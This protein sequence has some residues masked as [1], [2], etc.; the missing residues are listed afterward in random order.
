MLTEKFTYFS[1]PAIPD[2][3]LTFV[4]N[5]KEVSIDIEADGLHHYFA[6]VC[7]IQLNIAD[8]IYIVDPLENINTAMLFQA[9]GKK[10]KKSTFERN[11]QLQCIPVRTFFINYI[12]FS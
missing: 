7:L 11:L 12:F 9:I 2:K 6:R 3:F 4:E 8:K 5:A 1:G 10:K